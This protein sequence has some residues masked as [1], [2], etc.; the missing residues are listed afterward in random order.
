MKVWVH[1]H[2]IDPVEVTTWGDKD[3]KWVGGTGSATG[4]IA[5]GEH[6]GTVVQRT[7]WHSSH[8]PPLGQTDD[9]PIT[10]TVTKVALPERIDERTSI[11]VDPA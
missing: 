9:W 7:Y 2:E 4:Y 3:P 10:I 1:G 8:M 11:K 6:A 5:E